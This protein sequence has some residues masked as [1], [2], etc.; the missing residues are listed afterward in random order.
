MQTSTNKCKQTSRNSCYED[1]GPDQ[2]G[3]CNQ[4]ILTKVTNERL[5]NIYQKYLQLRCPA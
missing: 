5:F 4:T 3:K 1:N 2:E